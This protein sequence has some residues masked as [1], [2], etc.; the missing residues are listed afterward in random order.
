LQVIFV[1]I[2]PDRDT[3]NLL[4]NYVRAFDPSFIAL[5]GDA[6]ATAADIKSLLS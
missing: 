5:G 3:P 1:T 2:D 4:R 6:E